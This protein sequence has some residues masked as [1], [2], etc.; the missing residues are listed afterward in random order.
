MILY[1]YI[2]DDLEIFSIDIQGLF[3]YQSEIN[4]NYLYSLWTDDV[5]DDEI[6]VDEYFI[7]NISFHNALDEIPANIYNEDLYLKIIYYNN[8]L[9][10]YY[11]VSKLDNLNLKYFDKYRIYSGN[12][13]Y[14]KAYLDYSLNL[15]TIDAIPANSI[16]CFNYEQNLDSNYEIDNYLENFVGNSKDDNYIVNIIPKIYFTR[17][18][19]YGKMGESFGYYIKTSVA[20]ANY[21]GYYFI[22]EVLLFKITNI[23]TYKGSYT[24]G[25]YGL[26]FDN[27]V[28]PTLN[29][30]YNK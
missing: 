24:E 2:K 12:L 7:I 10:Y 29:C 21:G 3:L 17:A 27:S 14:D 23:T 8:D 19:E 18:C 20:E 6:I 16:E 22:S 11:V 13:F 5:S 15:R 1:Q 25:Y 30:V 26:D 9:E 4:G 28:S